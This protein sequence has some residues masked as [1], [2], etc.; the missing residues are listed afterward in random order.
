VRA[1]V[2]DV[3]R[4]TMQPALDEIKKQ[5]RAVRT[6]GLSARIHPQHPPCPINRPLINRPE[7]LPN[8]MPDR[9]RFEKSCQHVLV[10][11]LTE[12]ALSNF[13]SNL[14]SVS[15]RHTFC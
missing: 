8:H 6:V 13:S 3:C 7:R 9:P 1:Q 14:A 10:I 15:K 5:D 2:L 4:E 11:Y 12:D